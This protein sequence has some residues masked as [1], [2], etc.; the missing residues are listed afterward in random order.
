MRL[1]VSTLTP[2][3]ILVDRCISKQAISFLEVKEFEVVHLSVFIGEKAAQ[4]MM[5]V[6]ILRIVKEHN[7]VFFTADKNI[8]KNQIERQAVIENCAQVFAL[9]RNDLKAEIQA[10]YFL[11]NKN[12]I[13]QKSKRRGPFFYS[14]RKDSL[15]KNLIPKYS[16]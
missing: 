12:R 5:D 1:P 8:N 11:D 15:G 4:K 14:V 6:D 3:K 16:K 10:S 9:C 2:L 7:F 13:I